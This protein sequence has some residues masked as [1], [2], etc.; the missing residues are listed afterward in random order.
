MSLFP[1]VYVSYSFNSPICYMSL[2]LFVLCVCYAYIVILPT[3]LSLLILLFY[4]ANLIS[5]IWAIDF[6]E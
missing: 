5:G 3:V 2:M 1:I 6:A 4:L